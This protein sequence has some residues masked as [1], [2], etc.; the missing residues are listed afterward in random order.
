MVDALGLLDQYFETAFAAPDGIKR[1]RELILS[2]AMQGKLVPQDPNDQ[3][4]SE[5]LKEI[6]AE[7]KQL[8]KE[9]KI[10]KQKPL[11]DITPDEI[12]YDIPDS[13]EWVRLGNIVVV[14]SSKR[15][16]EKDYRASGIPFYR[17]R[18]IGELARNSF[19]EDRFYISQDKYQ[20][21]YTQHGVPKKDD[22]LLTSVGSIGDVWIVDEREFYYKDGNV[23]QLEKF[24]NIDSK[25]IVIFINSRLFGSP[26]ISMLK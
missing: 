8:V 11:P 12:P 10:K 16:F 19:C 25:Y 6:E 26:G 24:F 20:E 2:L 3:P 22:L 5:L 15:I 4:A 7:K 17:S 14:K 1:L 21:I 9:K 23:T 18:E 13:W